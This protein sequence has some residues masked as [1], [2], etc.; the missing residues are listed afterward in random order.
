MKR[1]SESFFGLH[2]DFHANPKGCTSPIGGT[3]KEEDIRKICR[4]IRPDF[5]QI[6]CKGHPGWA[7]YPTECGN[8][9]P[10]IQGDPLA[11]WRR[12]TREEGVALYLHYSGVIDNRYTTLHP[13]ENVLNADMVRRP[14]PVRPTGRYAD[15]LLIPQLCELAG[16]YGADGVWV[17]GEC[18]GT[19][20]D[21][22]PR[23]VAQFEQETRIDLKQSLPVKPSD[24]Y[25][26]EYR[27]FCRELF[28][29][30]L[31]HYT[32]AVH[33]KYPSFQIASN[34][35][36]TDHMPEPV[37]ADVDYISG[38]MNPQMS[39]ETARYAGRAIA[40]QGKC[41]DLMSW[42]FRAMDSRLPGHIVKHPVQIL[43][44]A[45]AVISLGGGFQN[46]I[47]QKPDG[48]PRMEQVLSMKAL[49]EFMRARRDY[50]FRGTFLHQ[51]ALFM[52]VHDRMLESEGLFARTGMNKL[53]GLT[54]L[55]CD[56]GCSLEHLSENG[57]ENADEYALIVIPELYKEPENATVKALLD[58]ADRGGSL[59]VTGENACR[60]FAAQGAP[61]EIGIALTAPQFSMDGDHLGRLRTAVSVYAENAVTFARMGS[62]YGKL[63]DSLA[64]VMPYGKGKL[65]FVGTD[66]GTAYTELAQYLHVDLIKALA[67]ALYDPAVRIEACD[68]RLEQ[69][70]LIK[71][72]HP[73]IQL[74]N[75]NGQ[76]RNPDSMT[77][78]H[79]PSCRDIVLSVKKELFRGSAVQ[80]PEGI[81]LK[82][83]E[84]SGRV[85]IRLDKIEIQSI[86]VL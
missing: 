49:G 16:K 70:D 65:A 33:A 59:L 32:Q 19:N 75:A 31:R 50:C 52:S 9:M 17:D 40:R 1:R 2:F 60:C 12:V 66:L 54:S 76:H 5:L 74:V 48:S 57:L 14:G 68:G 28:R 83:E 15:D 20:A 3:L 13:E 82:C 55:I 36:F 25:Y 86:V 85:L 10:N 64:I 63:N 41:W 11:L 51:A 69:V 45:A 80:Q 26:E 56:A 34:W 29:R 35:A 72:G 18:W 84:Q 47:T 81:E 23:T 53:M 39:F 22:D 46:Y 24:P 6:D 37:C 30:Y 73:C 77:E 8:A 4:E 58:Y 27:N 38:D 43:Q 62:E 21:F 79:I 67:D 71:D 42:N 61:V 44:E 7:S 78:S